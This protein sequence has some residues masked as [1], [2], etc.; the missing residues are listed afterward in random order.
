[1][2]SQSKGHGLVLLTCALNVGVSSKASGVWA[3]VEDHKV[4]FG[5][6]K[7]STGNL[8]AKSWD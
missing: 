1:M 5:G 7:S 4:F 8:G 2:G 6:G 3:P